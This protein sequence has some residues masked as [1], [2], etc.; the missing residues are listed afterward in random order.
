MDLE[1]GA[2][3]DTVDGMRSRP[4][5]RTRSELFASA[6]CWLPFA[7]TAAAAAAA[8][9]AAAAD[10]AIADLG[11]LDLWPLPCCWSCR[12]RVDQIPTRA[13][14]RAVCA[15]ENARDAAPAAAV[16]D[17]A[18]EEAAEDAEIDAD[19]DVLAPPPLRVLAMVPVVRVEREPGE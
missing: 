4:G 11:C 16:A 7:S 17:A 9:P 19:D 5:S 18:A 3:V 13:W 10:R 1:V 14:S 6:L 2:S 15:A 8:A 12:S